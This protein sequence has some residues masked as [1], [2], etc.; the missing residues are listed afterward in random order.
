MKN[1][2]LANYI[3][4]KL[5]EKGADKAEC[6]FSVQRVDELDAEHKKISMLR[7]SNSSK[8]GIKALANGKKG[9]INLNQLDMESVDKA[10]DDLHGLFSSAN[11]DDCEDIAPLLENKS[12]EKGPS[13]PDLD[14]CHERLDEFVGLCREEYPQVLFE[15]CSVS[16]RG[17][18]K[19]YVNT[20][21]AQL[22][23]KRGCYIYTAMFTAK[24]GQTVTSFNYF[25]N[26]SESVNQKIIDSPMAKTLID[27]SVMLLD[28]KSLD[29]SFTGTVLLAPQAVEDFLSFY[30]Q[31]FLSDMPMMQ[32]TTPLFD[33]LGEKIAGE[34]LVWSCQPKHPGLAAGYDITGDGYQAEDM[35][36]IENGVLK[37]FMLSRYG[38][39]KSGKDRSPNTG[40]A[41]IVQPGEQ[42]F[43]DMIKDIKEGV[44]LNRFSGGN[45][46]PNG[47]FSGVIKNSFLI[48]NGKLSH[49]ISEAMINGNLLEMFNNI[50]G[51]SKETM[52]FGDGILPYIACE[53]LLVSG[54]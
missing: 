34:K 52:N 17:E 18:E 44:L 42:A 37:N 7:T 25:G 39:K 12:F 54:K 30:A 3:F 8:L 51:I 1:I 48:K 16:F 36:V 13:K 10:I 31:S 32:K 47:D 20:N 23:S 41:N 9:V 22:E 19:L 46:A 40:G 49:G 5:K 29:T 15:R 27:Q 6:V 45:P 2:E 50:S 26:A 21:G 53:G 14:M 38:A 43:G 24:R 11:P 35:T 28:A 4:Q 33:K